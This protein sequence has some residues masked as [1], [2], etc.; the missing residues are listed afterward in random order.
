MLC[1]GLHEGIFPAQRAYRLATLVA[2]VGE[3]S[4]PYCFLPLTLPPCSNPFKLKKKPQPRG[5]N[6]FFGPLEGIRTPVLQNRNLLRYPAAPQA[7]KFEL[8]ENREK[9][10]EKVP[11]AH[12]NRFVK[13]NTFS[14][15]SSLLSFILN[16]PSVYSLY[17]LG[18]PLCQRHVSSHI[19]SMPR[20]A[21]QPSKLNALSALA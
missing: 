19:S 20:S 16:K 6:F 15:I 18:L 3:N 8:R 7:E 9:R 10:R 11:V 17:P 12:V 2:H 21:F 13:R 4:I 5:Y 1:F 14:F